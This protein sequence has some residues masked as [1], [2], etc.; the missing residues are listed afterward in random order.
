MRRSVETC[1]DGCNTSPGTAKSG[2]REYFEFGFGS[3]PGERD[4][5]SVRDEVTLEGGFK[6][7]GAVD[8]IE[9]HRSDSS[10]A[11]HGSQDRPQA[12]PDRE[13][14]H[15]WRRG[16]AA[17][18]LRQWP[19]RRRWGDRVAGAAVLLHVGRRLCRTSEI[20]LNEH[21]ACGGL[22]GAPGDR[23]RRRA[24]SLPPR[25]RR[26]PAGAA[27]SAPC[28]GPTCFAASDASRRTGLPICTALRSRP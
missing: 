14:H 24:D 6:L 18:A 12:G 7:R 25:Q 19:S 20:P 3:V 4:A 27:T 9:E 28:A 22:R 15:R 8:L 10:A 21:D 1:T 26:T 16:A 2:C 17:G 11:R 5:S 23:P 13:G